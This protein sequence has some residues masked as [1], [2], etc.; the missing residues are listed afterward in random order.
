MFARTYFPSRIS[1]IVGLWKA[2]LVEQEQPKIAE[3]IADPEN[4]DN[5]FADYRDSLEAEKFVKQKYSELPNAA[6][7]P[8]TSKSSRDIYKMWTLI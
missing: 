3:S 6:D 1:E 4:Y 8:T 7:Y 5:L 2:S